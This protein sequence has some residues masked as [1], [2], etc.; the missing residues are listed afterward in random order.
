MKRELAFLVCLMMVVSGLFFWNPA[1]QDGSSGLA[2]LPMIRDLVP[3]PPWSPNQASDPLMKLDRSLHPSASPMDIT[4]SEVILTILI[5]FND[6]TNSSTH[7]PAFFNDL[8]YN[9]STNSLNKYF[10]DNSYNLFC[11]T[12]NTTSKFYTASYSEAYYGTYEFEYKSGY[13]NTL[14]LALEALKAAD[15]DIDFTDYDQNNDGDVDHVLIVHAGKDDANDADGTGPSGDPQMWSHAVHG[16]GFTDKFDGKN[17]TD[18]TMLSEDD[19][20]GVFVHE[21]GHDL[22]LPDLYDTDYTTDGGCGFWELMASGSWNNGGKTP[23]QLGAWCK[24]ELGWLAPTLI[25]VDTEGLNAKRVEDNQT[26]FKIIVNNTNNEYFLVENRQKT[27]WDASLPG[28][29]LLIW[30]VNESA[31][32]NDND[33]YR[34]VDLEEWDND[35]YPREST[36]SWK[37]NATGMTP[38]TSPNTNDYSGKKTDIRIYNISASGNLM[39]FDVDLGNN[40]PAAPSPTAPSDSAWLGVSKPTVNWTFSD[41]DSGD[42]QTAYHVQVDGDSAFGSVD[43]DSGEVASTN[44][45]CTVG[46]ALVEG[47]WYWRACTR[48]TGGLWGSYSSGRSFNLDLTAPAAPTS[49]WAT[50]YDWTATNSFSIDWTAPTESGTSGIATGAYYKLDNAP[51]STTDGT[52]AASKPI[53]GMTV[54]SAGNHTVYIWLLDNV[55]NA[56]HSA[57]TTTYLNF[58]NVAP[59]NPNVL[60]SPTHTVNAWSNLSVIKAQWSGASDADSGLGGFSYVWDTNA[61]TLPDATKDASGNTGENSTPGLSDGTYYFHIRTVDAV[62]NWAVGAVHLGPFFIDLTPPGGVSGVS[63]STHTTGK[64]SNVNVVTVQWWG[65]ADSGSGIGRYAYSWDRAPD[66]VPDDTTTVTAG[67]TTLTSAPLTDASGWYFHIRVADGVFNWNSTA[68]HFGPFCIDTTP[69][70]NPGSFAMLS[71]HAVGIWSP[72]RLVKV[73]WSGHTDALSGVEGF[74]ISWDRDPAGIPDLT[75]D[76]SGAGYDESDQSGVCF[77]HIRAA[78]VAGNWATSVFTVGPIQI[79][80]D[81]PSAPQAVVEKPLTNSNALRWS[82]S[83]AT[84]A[85]SGVAYYLVWI[86]NDPARPQDGMQDRTPTNSYTCRNALDGMTYYLQVRAVDMVG[87]AGQYGALSGGVLVD[88]SPPRDVRV[89]INSGAALT[90][91]P[92]VRLALEAHDAVSGVAD[93]RFSQDGIEW[94]AW[95]PFEDARELALTPGDGLRTVH[96]QVRD[97]AGNEARPVRSSIVLDTVGPQ[98]VSFGQVGG[99]AST[100]SRQ[101]ALEVSASDAHSRVVSVR[102]SADGERWEPW[103]PYGAVLPWE[104]SSGDGSKDIYIQARD[105]AGNIGF[106]SKISILLDTTAPGKPVVTSPTHPKGDLWYNL[107]QL[108]FGW[109]APPDASGIAGY[110]WII[111]PETRDEPGL[112]VQL[113]STAVRLP[114]PGEGRWHFKIRAID[115]SGNCGEAATFSVRIDLGGPVPPRTE[116]PSDN[117]EF[118]PADQVTLSWSGAQDALSGVQGYFVQVDGN[119]DYSSPEWE[120]V[121]D[122]TSYVLPPLPE[123]SYHWH[124]RSRDVAGNWGEYGTGSVFGIHTPVK[125][126]PE[127]HK[128][129]FLSLSNPLFLLALVVVLVL[130]IGGA[131][132]AARRRK[133]EPPAEAPAQDAGQQVKWA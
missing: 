53:T 111:T 77:L 102:L 60:S 42:S 46:S 22:G 99:S 55:G 87:N 47:K 113:T 49:A 40:A 86:V 44:P 104:L 123:G 116:L 17:V 110:A 9:A 118:L 27:G 129:P 76:I 33:K 48:D 103:Q 89:I 106:S 90:A 56:N 75:L 24:K 94:T 105:L 128:E 131:A 15:A 93:M 45:Y 115:G 52:W 16:T 92:S 114:V 101:V 84:D 112:S 64:W 12:G 81:A 39:Y 26:A 8:M 65:A 85:G 63:S 14:D 2:T 34:L 5:N 126:I 125:P 91:V 74:S 127:S 58:D 132:M 4:G 61:N 117:W 107:A 41:S 13:G 57:R 36:D 71:K 25:N 130:V 10:K 73:A 100:A 79:D 7:T 70:S 29:G 97:M 23:S 20:V 121:V 59:N 51:T 72:D 43:W 19:P 50:P 109:Q 35:D 83:P 124:V 1:G 82:W 3:S 133:K 18:Y 108:E 6:T 69:P 88:L 21:F 67:I 119:A 96:F 68:F 54:G 78:D 80:L 30:H 95:E 122:P 38:N 32:D 37:S 66:T 11:V 28:S 120:G 31:Y 98:I 62:G